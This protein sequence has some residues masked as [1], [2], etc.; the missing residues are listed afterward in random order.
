MSAAVK[1]VGGHICDKG[2]FDTIRL[3]GSKRRKD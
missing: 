1:V 3:M 2:R